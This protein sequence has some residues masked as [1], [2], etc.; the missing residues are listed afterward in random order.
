VA[1]TAAPTAAAPAFRAVQRV[2]WETAVGAT[3]V[4]VWT[5]GAVTEGRFSHLRLDGPPPRE[6]VKLRGV[7]SSTVPPRLEVATPELLQIR[8][9]LHRLPTGDELHLVLD[10]GSPATRLVTATAAG[11]RLE[12]RLVSRSAAR[13]DS[14]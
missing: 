13:P 3:V 8:T 7:A 9:G 10:L 1:P 12:L 4:T 14:R 5:D 2:T 6:V 11:D